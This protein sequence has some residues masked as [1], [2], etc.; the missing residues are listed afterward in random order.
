MKLHIII[1][2]MHIYYKYFFQLRENKI[3]RL[4]STIDGE[5]RDT[6][7]VYYTIR[8]IDNIRKNLEGL[9]HDLTM[10]ICFD[11]KSKRKD[12]DAEYKSGRA[13][14]LDDGDFGNLIV[15]E[16]MLKDAGYNV[17]K[18]EGYEADDIV[19]YLIR[20]YS[21][22]YEY[23][24]IY[25]NDKDLLINIKDNVGVMRFKQYKG[26]TQVEKKNYEEYLEKEFKV[27]I[28]YNMLGLYLSS[29]GD[30]AD[31]IKG[32][33]KFGPKAFSKLLTKVM[34]TCDVD[35]ATCGDYKQLEKVIKACEQHLTHEQFEQLNNS[36][37]LVSNLDLDV[38]VKRP[39]SKSTEEL[40]RIT[41]EKLQFYS[42]I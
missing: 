12:Q 1:D 16:A 2:F 25:T 14:S 42:L 22:E 41:Y 5:E 6:S 26:Y 17:Y 33:S 18:F 20:Q 28:P 29:A 3:K 10:S 19:N 8:D 39:D 30:S 31:K 38:E 11:M 40:R 23:N 24:I 27:F 15:I 7:L 37:K 36:F 4:S 32:I 35:M 9:G 34:S 21:N 13:N